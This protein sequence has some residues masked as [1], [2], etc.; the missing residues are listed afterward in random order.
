MD[1]IEPG[2][3][4][5]REDAISEAFVARTT[6]LTTAREEQVE[7]REAA[8]A[9]SGLESQ[10][11][12]LPDEAKFSSAEDLELEQEE[13]AA[14]VED[15]TVEMEPASEDQGPPTMEWLKA[16]IVDYINST[17]GTPRDELEAMTKAEMLD[18]FV[19]ADG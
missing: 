2:G 12:E 8:E 15:D 3:M 10:E 13:A 9:E 11:S 17:T 7:E 14:A 5:S 18:R 16:D 4:I 19:D 1:E 6:A